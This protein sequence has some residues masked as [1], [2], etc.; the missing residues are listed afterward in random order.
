[1][2]VDSKVVFG[3]VAGAAIGAIAGILLAPDKGSG[4]RQKIK[5]GLGEAGS[6]FKNAVGDFADTVKEKYR[7]AKDESK[8][9]AQA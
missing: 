4:T 6:G 3:L 7:A 9:R 2:K 8:G 5:D 1:M